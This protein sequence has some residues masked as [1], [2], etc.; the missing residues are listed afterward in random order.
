MH[1]ALIKRRAANLA[2]AAGR[3]FRWYSEGLS[4]IRANAGIAPDGTNTAVKL[5]ANT[6]TYPHYIYGGHAP[7]VQLNVP[8]TFSVYAKSAG[9]RYTRISY[10]RDGALR[11]INLD[12]LTGAYTMPPPGSVNRPLAYR[13]E[14]L[15]DGWY[16]VSITEAAAKN[17]QPAPEIVFTDANANFHIPGD[18]TSG[19]LLWGYQINPGGPAPYNP[20]PPPV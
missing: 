19:I 4:E 11:S 8:Y 9:W 12:L 2:P 7:V 3:G 16:R 10:Y 6:S 14:T 17:N 1:A 18:G 20:A 13:V 15:S 5:T